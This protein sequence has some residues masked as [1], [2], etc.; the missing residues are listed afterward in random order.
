MFLSITEV[1]NAYPHVR[2]KDIK[3]VIQLKEPYSQVQF[4]MA[5]GK[6]RAKRVYLKSDIEKIFWEIPQ[7]V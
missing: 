3:T 5:N 6:D 2:R 4:V 7:Q 1:Y